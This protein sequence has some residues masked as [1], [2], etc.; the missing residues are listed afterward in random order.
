MFRKHHLKQ[1]FARPEPESTSDGEYT[2]DVMEDDDTATAAAVVSEESEKPRT[3]QAQQAV[4]MAASASSE[5]ESLTPEVV[6][7]LPVALVME[8]VVTVCHPRKQPTLPEAQ[9]IEAEVALS[10]T[11]AP[12]QEE[13]KRVLRTSAT[14]SLPPPPS[15]PPPTGPPP[16]LALALRSMDIADGEA[17]P[18]P[19][20]ISTAMTAEVHEQAPATPTAR[21][22]ADP[23]ITLTAVAFEVICADVHPIAAVPEVVHLQPADCRRHVWHVESESA[24]RCK[25]QTASSLQL[26]R[27]APDNLARRLD[28]ALEQKS[29]HRHAAAESVDSEDQ[30]HDLARRLDAALEQRLLP[31]AESES[32]E[33]LARRLDE[34]LERSLAQAAPV[35]PVVTMSESSTVTPRVFALPASNASPSSAV[36]YSIQEEEPQSPVP[37]A[38]FEL[39]HDDNDKPYRGADLETIVS[40]DAFESDLDDNFEGT[41]KVVNTDSS[42]S[43][44]SNG[45]P[46]TAIEDAYVEEDDI[47]NNYDGVNFSSPR[48]PATATL[49]S[50]R[51]DDTPT[52]S[53]A[54]FVDL[55]P[56][57]ECAVFH[58]V[59]CALV[60]PPAPELHTIP[61]LPS[62]LVSLVKISL[63][64]EQATLVQLQSP[65]QIERVTL[66]LPPLRR[67]PD[68]LTPPRSP[69]VVLAPVEKLPQSPAAMTVEPSVPSPPSVPREMVLPSPLAP[70]VT[71][72]T[73]E[74]TSTTTTTTTTPPTPMPV[75]VTMPTT[76]GDEEILDNNNNND[77]DNDN[78]DHQDDRE[79]EA[80]AEAELNFGEDEPLSSDKTNSPLPQS[81]FQE[82]TASFVVQSTPN[83]HLQLPVS[84]SS[85]RRPVAK[86]QQQRTPVQRNPSTGTLFFDPG[87]LQSK[88]S[89][90]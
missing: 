87:A 16:A 42:A 54:E 73:A 46:Y 20:Q 66:T 21:P 18:S 60:P 51:S 81:P 88:S 5:P 75:Q 72:S 10:V 56:P 13:A 28:A 52:N 12:L 67:R 17:P 59:R 1:E 32:P 40:E 24:I 7:Q 31:P 89:V 82:Q 33:A 57:L 84:T 90:G 68:L 79:M 41:D 65:Q 49:E 30:A 83:T 35:A 39:D 27:E 85:Q 64:L 37:S 70:P 36:I 9:L 71:T 76:A 25:A 74:A 34:A 86:A 19:Q 26:D 22:M 4:V 48:A 6:V 63:P 45:S 78:A 2:D 47:D 8:V 77:N 50:M 61:D 14:T 69:T 15:I 58:V 3:R 80:E 43:N 62:A 55:P 29:L 53:L 44:I 11:T 23:V 38:G